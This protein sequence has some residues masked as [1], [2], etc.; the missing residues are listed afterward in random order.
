MATKVAVLLSTYNGE[1]FL[2]EQMESIILQQDVDV[3]I[4][5]RDDGSTDHT[6][7]IL[8]SYEDKVPLNISIGSNIGYK[9]SFLQLLARVPQTFEYYC[10]ADE[11]DVWAA[12]KIISGITM[13]QENAGSSVY[14]SA[15]EYVDESLRRLRIR[16]YPDQT[17]SVE[18]LFTRMRFAGCTSVFPSE[19]LAICQSVIGD[20]PSSIAVSHDLFLLSVG[21]ALCGPIVVDHIPHIKYRRSSGTI[22]SGGHSVRRRMH[23]EYQRL[24]TQDK[25]NVFARI[26]LQHHPKVES[27]SYLHTCM[28]YQRRINAKIRLMGITA[29]KKYNTNLLL[30]WAA[31]LKILLNTF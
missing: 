16:D 2:R 26:L 1:R 13:L 14:V 25:L 18:S 29:S 31:I 3:S 5:V 4:F 6:V 12:D 17:I 8:E 9:Q 22:T 19:T 10:F 7:D 27:V 24:R 15:L 28:D 30:R 20:D 11:D 23:Y 21:V